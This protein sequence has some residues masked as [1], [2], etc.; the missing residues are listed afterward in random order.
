MSIHLFTLLSAYISA[1]VIC[2]VTVHLKEI[3]KWET[4]CKF[5]WIICNKNCH[6]TGPVRQHFPR[7]CTCI[8]ME[9]H[10]QQRG[11]VRE[12]EHW[13]KSLELRRNVWKITSFEAQ[14]EEGLKC[15]FF[16]CI[17]SLSW[18]LRE[19]GQSL[20]ISHVQ[21]GTGNVENIVK[22]CEWINFSIERKHFWNSRETVT[23]SRTAVHEVNY[24]TDFSCCKD[25][26]GIS[27]F[28]FSDNVTTSPTKRWASR[29]ATWNQRYTVI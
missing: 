17:L 15:S 20:W 7:L 25:K 27:I 11:T 4:W 26:L 6:I 16:S 19:A 28:C 18:N 12:N 8:F 2:W 3:E 23:F 1:L 22:L 10:Y 14:V 21:V 24:L 29:N 13:Q 5:S 9:G